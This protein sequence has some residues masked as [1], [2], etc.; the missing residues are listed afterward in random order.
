MIIYLTTNNINGKIYIGKYCGTRE[1]YLG[2]GKYIKRAIKKDGKE[3]FSRITLEDGITDHGYLCKREIYW[4]KFYDSM[5]LEIGYNLCEGGKGILGYRHTEESLRKMSE[6]HPNQTGINSPWWGKH[7][8]EETCKKMSKAQSGINHPMYGKHPSDETRNRMSEA[9]KGEKNHMFGKHP[10]EETRRKMSISAKNK[11]PITEETRKNMSEV[12]KGEN[13]GMYG[14]HH[15]DETKEKMSKNHADFNGINHPRIIKKEMVLEI[16]ELLEKD[17]PITEIAKKTHISDPT[18]RKV[19]NG[20]YN[21]IYNL[22][23]TTE[24]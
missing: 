15:S 9:R 7:H 22:P 13:N 3:N 17:M 21:E 18:I 1:S 10:S 6:N 23:E 4:I 11:P 16:L 14:Q 24:T 8:S 20:G 19:K 5:N 12:Q 2:S